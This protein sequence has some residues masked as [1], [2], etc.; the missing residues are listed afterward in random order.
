MVYEIQVHP[1]AEMEIWAAVDWYDQQKTDLGKDFARELDRVIAAI[2]S[3]DHL[4]FQK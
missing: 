1:L 2:I 4:D 3:P